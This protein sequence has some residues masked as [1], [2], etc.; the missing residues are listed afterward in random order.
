MEVIQLNGN[1]ITFKTNITKYLLYSCRENLKHDQTFPEVRKK[2][3]K[4]KKL[5]TNL[6]FFLTLVVVTLKK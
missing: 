2:F 6:K 4:S 3:E 5:K 1:L